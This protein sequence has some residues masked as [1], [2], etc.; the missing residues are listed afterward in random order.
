MTI[1][2][3]KQEH[4]GV[5]ASRRKW[6][7]AGAAVLVAGGAAVYAAGWTGA[8]GVSAVTVEG[9]TS[10]DPGQL[11]SVA[12][13]PKGTPMMRVDVRAATARLSDLPQVA[14]VDVHRQWPRTV[15]I[16]VS[17]RTAVAMQKAADGWE[18]LDENGAAF[19]VASEKPKDLP[20][21][22]R[23]PDEAANT[24]MLQAL[25]GM[26]QQVRAR[27][28]SISAESPNSL[29]LQLRKSQAVVSWGSAADSDYKSAVLSVLLG[30]DSGW[31][32]VSNPDTPTTA[33]GPP[34]PA[35]PSPSA[36]PQGSVAPTPAASPEAGLD[37]PT[38]IPTPSVAAAET[39]VGV[40]AD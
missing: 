30:T 36:S 20:T 21:V 11:V 4:T 2:E 22:E 1:T 13:I 24:A 27:V 29:M 18:L 5:P 39:P 38:P 15:V 33:D 19:A 23:S 8:M 3:P 40:V 35:T 37:T 9:T 34:I 6:V 28:A 16:T 31:Y 26:S 25:A 14:S 32:D 10:M 12:G 7:V 17:E